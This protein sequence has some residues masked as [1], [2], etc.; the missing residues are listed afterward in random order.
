MAAQILFGLRTGEGRCACLRMLRHQLV[1]L[2]AHVGVDRRLV[3]GNDPLR[4]GGVGHVLCLRMK[5][6]K[7]LGC[8]LRLRQLRFAAMVIQRVQVQMFIDGTLLQFRRAQSRFP[9][10][11]LR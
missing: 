11:P 8:G 6:C 10:F 7:H 3:L 1:D 5:V 4:Y 9:G 2:F